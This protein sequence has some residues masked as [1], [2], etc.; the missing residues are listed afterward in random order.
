MFVPICS[1]CSELAVRA[2]FPM[3]VL[4]R[5]PTVCSILAEMLPLSLS[6]YAGAS[7]HQCPM[8]REKNSFNWV[9]VLIVTYIWAYL[10]IHSYFL[11]YKPPSL[12]R[13]RPG[14]EN[15]AKSQ[16]KISYF[17][18]VLRIIKSLLF[19]VF[20]VV[21]CLHNCLIMSLRHTKFSKSSWHGRRFIQEY[22]MDNA[23]L[24]AQWKMRKKLF[25]PFTLSTIDSIWRLTFPKCCSHHT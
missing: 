11:V 16:R 6:L 24:K 14:K 23:D 4:L 17:I 9:Y 22:E 10:W 5:P 15:M 2:G 8:T 20:L 21:F 25:Y 13:I 19:Y 18:L 7:S 1:P 12:I 3:V